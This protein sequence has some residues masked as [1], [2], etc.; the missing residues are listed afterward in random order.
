VLLE[1]LFFVALALATTT[2]LAV[3]P[4]VCRARIWIGL[5]AGLSALALAGWLLALATGDRRLPIAAGRG[6]PA[7]RAWQD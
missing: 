6:V 2:L 4:G 1:S 3:L 5:P 7:G